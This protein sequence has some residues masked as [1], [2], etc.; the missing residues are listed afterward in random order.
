M[1]RGTLSHHKKRPSKDDG[2]L[3]A[4]IHFNAHKPLKKNEQ[5]RRV[6]SKRK[7]GKKQSADKQNERELNSKASLGWKTKKI[8]EPSPQTV[9]N[10]SPTI[11][12]V[13]ETSDVQ[14]SLIPTITKVHKKREFSQAH[15]NKLKQGKFLAKK[16]REDRVKHQL[17]EIVRVYF[18]PKVQTNKKKVEIKAIE[19][20]QTLLQAFFNGRCLKDLVT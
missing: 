16:L 17:E 7:C 2:P 18:T 19:Q 5:N 12:K 3:T 8:D 4:S 20:L 1:V 15:K 9:N 6:S 13:E 11:I 14:P 10:Q